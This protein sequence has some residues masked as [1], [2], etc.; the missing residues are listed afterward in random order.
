MREQF[1][2][3][4]ESGCIVTNEFCHSV[5]LVTLSCYTCDIELSCK[6]RVSHTCDSSSTLMLHCLYGILSSTENAHDCISSSHSQVYFLKC[7]V[8]SVCMIL[9]L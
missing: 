3:A 8:H 6:V 1:F 7:F 4:G 5:K 9:C 2:V